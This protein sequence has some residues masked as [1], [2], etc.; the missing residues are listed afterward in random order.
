MGAGAVLLSLLAAQV[1]QHT[2]SALAHNLAGVFMFAAFILV[3]VLGIAPWVGSF[4][5]KH[6]IQNTRGYRS[7]Y[8]AEPDKEGG[9]YLSQGWRRKWERESLRNWKAFGLYIEPDEKN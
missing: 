8:A 4:A 1:D 5:L 6:P 2:G 9:P 3:V 7:D